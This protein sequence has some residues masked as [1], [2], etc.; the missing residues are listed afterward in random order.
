MVQPAKIVGIALWT[1]VGGKIR[2][3]KLN[4]MGRKTEE[5]VKTNLEMEGLIRDQKGSRQRKDNLERERE[6]ERERDVCNRLFRCR[7]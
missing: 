5:N 7:N 3:R 1:S 2:K 4:D 6:R